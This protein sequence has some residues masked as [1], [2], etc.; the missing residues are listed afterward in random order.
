MFKAGHIAL[1]ALVLA[2][3]CSDS[4]PPDSNTQVFQTVDEVAAARRAGQQKTWKQT[5]LDVMR[6]ERPDVAA[7]AD[8]D[9]A[10]ILTADGVRQRVEL[11]EMSATL[12]AQPD[13][14]YVI[15]RD[16]LQRQLIPF[17]QERLA[18]VSFESIRKRVRPM[19][20]NGADAQDI[21]MQLGSAVPTRTVFADLYWIP[22]VKWEAPRPAT[23]IGPKVASSWNISADEI[24]KIAISNLAGDP[25][26]SAFEVTSFGTLGRVGSLKSNVDPALILSPNFLSVARRALD[27]SEN[28]ALL[29]ATP[30][31]VRFLPAN[32]KRLM[33]S[34]YPNWKS[35][36]PNNRKALAKQPL[37]LSEQGI[38]GLVYNPPVIL[39]RPTS[40]PTTNPMSQFQ[41]K[42]PTSRPAKPAAKPYIVR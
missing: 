33:D 21:S 12:T 31:D 35:I 38:T 4:T 39:I 7:A 25:V 14:V 11:N 2:A 29:L 1:L 20:L 13:Q 30:Q 9:L 34:I 26:E 36:I 40:M 15:L 37:Q 8:S 32:E 16:Y 42:R 41:S 27:T 6:E 5:A 3:G 17:D 24:T 22:V 23:P 10:I 19:L 28:L 18:H